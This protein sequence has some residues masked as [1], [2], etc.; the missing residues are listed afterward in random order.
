VLFR[1]ATFVG[2]CVEFVAAI[3]WLSELF[4][5]GSRRKKS[6]G[7]TQA[8]ASIG[9]LLDGDRRQRLGDRPRQHT[10]RASNFGTLQRPR[11]LALH[12]ADGL[13]PA[14]PI[15]LLLPFVPE[16]Q[17]WL[18]RRE[19]GTLRRASFGELFSRHRVAP[20]W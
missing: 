16:S 1:S 4:R 15:A 10:A 19:A 2:V 9:G 18:A 13:M 3:T 5:I 12:P 6:S 8:F 20:P 7:G 17:A 14:I 11:Q